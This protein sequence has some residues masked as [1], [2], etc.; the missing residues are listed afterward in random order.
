MTH[1]ATRRAD[2][3]SGGEAQRVAI[4]RALS[5]RP[6]ALMADEPVASLDPDAAEAVMGLL[7]DL[8]TR[9]GLG[10]LCVLHQPDLA[11][12]FA[13][14]IAGLRRGRIAFDLPARL[15]GAGAVRALYGDGEG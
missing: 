10:V 12:R 15:V 8:A 1:V 3:L 13:D 6:Q 4:A 2:S 7:R 9:D 11:L 14:R 5:Q